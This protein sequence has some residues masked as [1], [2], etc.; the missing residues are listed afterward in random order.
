M[1]TEF[2]VELS[3]EVLHQIG[4]NK[5]YNVAR[6]LRKNF[7]EGKDFLIIS[8]PINFSQHGGHNIKRYMMTK[9]TSDLL[10]SSYNLKHKYIVNN[11]IRPVVMSVENSTIGFISNALK[12]L[13]E[14]KREYVIGDYRVDMYIPTLNVCLEC[15]EFGHMSYNSDAE[16]TRQRFIETKLSCTFIRF[17]PN[18]SGFDISDV[19]KDILRIYAERISA[20][21]C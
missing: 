9:K 3:S 21:K 14:M 4:T 20:T 15:D 12:P 5:K 17:N 10:I 7:Y 1:E 6:F 18:Q 11:T 19:I 8:G 2:T 13:F 16:V